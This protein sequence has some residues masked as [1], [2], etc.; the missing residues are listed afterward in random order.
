[1]TDT[2]DAEP[3]ELPNAVENPGNRTWNYPAPHPTGCTCWF[4]EEEI[5]DD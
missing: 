2:D 5:D 4:C 1:M 3:D